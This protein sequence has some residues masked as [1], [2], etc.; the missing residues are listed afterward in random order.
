MGI[1]PSGAVVPG[2]TN[3]FKHNPVSAHDPKSH[4]MATGLGMP[5]DVLDDPVTC[6]TKDSWNLM[7]SSS[8]GLELILGLA[9]STGETIGHHSLP[10]TRKGTAQGGGGSAG[11]LSLLMTASLMNSALVIP[12]RAA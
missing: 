4:G 5:N 2:V 11:G 10:M 9:V 6:T 1:V 7:P 3:G 12:S 8:M